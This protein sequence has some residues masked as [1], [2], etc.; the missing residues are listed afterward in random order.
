MF[1]CLRIVFCIYLRVLF[2]LS[3]GV[4]FD[5][6][7]YYFYASRAFSIYTW[8]ASMSSAVSI[9][10]S[11]SCGSTVMVTDFATVGYFISGLCY[12]VVV[13]YTSVLHDG[14][15]LPLPTLARSITLWSVIV[16]GC[17]GY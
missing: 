16:R 9:L 15:S 6:I 3:G 7:A 14:R 8:R 11:S 13:S 10:R 17:Y 2:I 1:I 12:C 5:S 4:Y